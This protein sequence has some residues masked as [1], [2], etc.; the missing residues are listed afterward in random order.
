MADR[1]WYFIMV[2]MVYLAIAWCLTWIAI[3]I[4]GI[5]NTPQP[6]RTLRI[7]PAGNPRDDT[8]TD[9]STGTLAGAVWDALSMPTV[10]KH[11][12]RLWFFLIVFHIALILLILAHLDLLPQITIMAP[13]SVHMV[14]FGAIGMVVTI[15]LLYF[16]FRRF[17]SPVREISVPGDFLLLFLLFCIAITG[18]TISWGNSWSQDGFVMTKADFG[19]YLNSLITFSFADPREFLSGSHYAVIGMHVLLAN[20]FLLVFPFTKMMHAFFAVPMNKLRR[21]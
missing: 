2:P 5:I 12:P 3:K 17:R 10:R 19:G 14:G 20:I 7:F 16:L 18:D 6:P 13:D 21:G 8:A 9:P 15:S 1:I 11:E 4:V